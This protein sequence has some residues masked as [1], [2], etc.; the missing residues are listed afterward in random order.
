MQYETAKVTAKRILIIDDEDDIREVAELTLEVV[1]G[2]EV[3]TASSGTQG[4]AKAAAEQPDVILLDIMMPE[5][6][7]VATLQKLRANPATQHIPVIF[8]SAK[9]HLVDWHR[10]TELGV[11]A[12]IAKPF[13][14]MTLAAQVA[15]ALGWS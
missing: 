2:W 5:M 13:N 8:L 14:P 3:S 6:D 4:L 7:G 10:F 9:T 15:E 12:A 1:G 11:R